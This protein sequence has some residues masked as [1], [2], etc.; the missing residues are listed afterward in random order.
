MEHGCCKKKKGAG[1]SNL[2]SLHF[3]KLGLL[4]LLL[5]VLVL[6]LVLFLLSCGLWCSR[7]VHL[8]AHKAV[9]G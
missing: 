5:L 2:G 4:L 9:L 8:C 1:C 3:L 7:K 6:V